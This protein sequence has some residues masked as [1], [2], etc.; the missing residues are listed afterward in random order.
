MRSWKRGNLI[1]V[2][3]ESS[4]LLH[5]ELRANIVLI[6]TFLSPPPLVDSVAMFLVGIRNYS[7]RGK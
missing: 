3:S 6:I 1:S 7:R 5:T 2:N 4:L